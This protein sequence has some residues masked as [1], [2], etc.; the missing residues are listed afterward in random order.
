MP[1]RAVPESYFVAT[2]RQ[3]GRTPKWSWE[4]RREPEPL[5]VTLKGNGFPT[6]GAVKIAGERAL[7]VL[8]ATIAQEENDA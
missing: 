6:E 3:R 1:A 7:R 4:I 8:L 5:G 2:H